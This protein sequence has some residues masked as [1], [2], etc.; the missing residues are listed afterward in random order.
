M[1]STWVF[2]S[3][4]RIDTLI[5]LRKVKPNLRKHPQ[6]F[7][8]RLFK[9]SARQLNKPIAL[10]QA[11]DK[12]NPNGRHHMEESREGWHSPIII[13]RHVNNILTIFTSVL[14]VCISSVMYFVLIWHYHLQALV[15]TI[16]LASSPRV[17]EA[18]LTQKVIC[19]NSKLTVFAS[20][21]TFIGVVVW[22]V[23][24]CR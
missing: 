2:I 10:W 3:C 16:I 18:R 5:C 21:V 12:N 4:Y 14:V 17:P 13:K 23:I 9:T 11:L 8:I 24:H 7:N 1:L 20:V 15:S 19:S 6:T 22:I